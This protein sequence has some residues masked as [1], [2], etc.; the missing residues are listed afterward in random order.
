MSYLRASKIPVTRP[1][2]WCRCELTWP[3]KKWATK[4]VAHI[5]SRWASDQTLRS[6]RKRY[7][8]W[9]YLR[10]TK[11]P[12]LHAPP[13]HWLGLWLTRE[14]E[15]SQPRPERPRGE[16]SFSFAT[17]S[18]VNGNNGR[19]LDFWKKW[20]LPQLRFF[21]NVIILCTLQ[22]QRNFNTTSSSSTH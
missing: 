15:L 8:F 3:T 11:G 18:Y 7:A 6:Y 4:L 22:S 19:A 13:P 5:V 16:K 1:T 14:E 20:V 2:L 10:K 21:S 12:Q 9:S 17:Y